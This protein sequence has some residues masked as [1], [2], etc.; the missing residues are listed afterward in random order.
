MLRSTVKGVKIE[1]DPSHNNLG[2][3]EGSRSLKIPK[4]V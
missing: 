4:S 2:D 3:A 1:G